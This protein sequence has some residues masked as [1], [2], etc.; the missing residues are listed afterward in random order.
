MPSLR[1]SLAELAG[2][3]KK[4]VPMLSVPDIA[5]TLGWYASI[6]FTELG[7]FAD[8]GLVNWGMLSFGK[9]ELMLRLGPA[10]SPNDVSLWLYTDRVDDLYKTFKSAPPGAIDFVEELYDPFYGGRQF[11]IRDLNGYALYFL[12]PAG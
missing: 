3:I 12:Q 2:S 9:V 11:G 7:R 10:P 6:G 1:E 4:G 8:D 5:A